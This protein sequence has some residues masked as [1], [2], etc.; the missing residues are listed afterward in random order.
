M[1]STELGAADRH[2]PTDPGPL[3]WHGDQGLRK[4]AISNPCSLRAWC[5]RFIVHFSSRARPEELQRATIAIWCRSSLRLQRGLD[6]PEAAVYCSG[7]AAAG[8]HQSQ[9]PRHQGIAM[10]VCVPKRKRRSSWLASFSVRDRPMSSIRMMT[11]G[12]RWV[13]LSRLDSKGGPRGDRADLAVVKTEGW[14]VKGS[15]CDRADAARGRLC[16]VRRCR[17]GNTQVDQRQPLARPSVRSPCPNPNRHRV[18]VSRHDQYHAGARDLMIN[19]SG[20]L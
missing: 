8:L 14:C 18:Y 6:S 1:I 9:T 16:V 5:L 12:R 13:N 10:V 17:G 15:G 11:A 3:P 7:R 20:R 4:G 2:P 19:F